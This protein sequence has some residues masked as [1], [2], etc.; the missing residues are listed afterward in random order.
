MSK[1]QSPMLAKSNFQK[2]GD[3]LPGIVAN[4]QAGSTHAKIT[5]GEHSKIIA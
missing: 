2:G 1:I 3:S 5:F 4:P